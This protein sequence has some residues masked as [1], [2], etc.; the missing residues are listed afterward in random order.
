MAD[1]Y[2]VMRLETLGGVLLALCAALPAPAQD[3]QPKYQSGWPCAG[4]VDQ[5]FVRTSEATGGKVLLFTPTELSGVVD[6]MQASRGH[7]ATV[8]RTANQLEDD[9]HEFDIPIDSTIQSAYFFITLQCLREVALFQPSGDT[10]AIDA[11]GVG[12]QAFQAVRLVTVEAPQAGIWKVRAAGRGWFSLIVSARTD[13]KLT[14][15]SLSRD[16]TPIR[17]VAP[18][19]Q[20]VEIE[21]NLSG[22]SGPTDFQLIS[23]AGEPLQTFEPEGDRETAAGTTYTASVTLPRVEFRLVITGVDPNGFRYQRVTPDLFIDGR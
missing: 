17:G 5:T 18:L 13:L 8:F 3:Q 15:V 22:A 23:M 6:E 1:T 20:P 21:A 7:D 12:Y 11:P 14:S 4:R 2:R 10:L 9:I 16:G 19:G